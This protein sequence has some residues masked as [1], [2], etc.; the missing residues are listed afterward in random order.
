MTS[1]SRS[2]LSDNDVPITNA[3]SMFTYTRVTPS[4]LPV[5]LKWYAHAVAEKLVTSPRVHDEL[6][7]EFSNESDMCTSSSFQA[8]QVHIS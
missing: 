5:D 8:P 6:H 1:Y 2:P 7:G 4:L 3:P